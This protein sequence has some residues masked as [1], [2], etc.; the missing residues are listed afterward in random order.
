MRN[1]RARWAL[2]E[3]MIR[4]ALVPLLIA[5]GMLL[6]PASAAA[7]TYTTSVDARDYAGPAARD[8]AR[9]SS[10]LDDVGNWRVVVSLHAASTSETRA[11]TRAY[12]TP[13]RGGRC[14][15]EPVATLRGSTDPARP[16]SSYFSSQSAPDARASRTTEQG[17]QQITFAVSDRGLAGLDPAT[18]CVLPL[19]LSQDNARFDVLDR[20]LV[21]AET[22]A[23]EPPADPAT[24]PPDCT[25]GGSCPSPPSPDT[26][27][28]PPT[29][30]VVTDRT[31]PRF[32]LARATRR[33][34]A[35]RSGL[36][37]V[38]LIDIT[39]AGR[40]VVVLRTATTTV[41][42]ASV[43]VRPEAR[44][45]SVRLTASGRALLRRRSRIALRVSATLVD[46]AGNRSRRTR[47]TSLG[48][49]QMR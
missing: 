48:R 16:E 2:G 10:T 25:P 9:V 49:G 46:A 36:V 35:S 41:G 32:R 5:A 8:L 20:P 42:R 11:Y 31:A 40:A 39:E 12:L 38:G 3:Q 6:V 29:T 45:V 18:L 44:G 13:Y 26:G 1:L 22:A 14:G 19:E 4:S 15:G 43:A 30:P 24:P 21:F 7:G 33:L 34:T 37:R 28:R 27:S 17:G 47:A 23:P